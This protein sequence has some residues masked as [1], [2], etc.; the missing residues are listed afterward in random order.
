MTTL[1]PNSSEPA[2]PLPTLCIASENLRSLAHNTNIDST[3]FQSVLVSAIQVLDQVFLAEKH[4]AT[5]AISL[6]Q[7]RKLAN[8]VE[9]IKFAQFS[10]R[11]LLNDQGTRILQLQNPSSATEDDSSISWWFHLTEGI[12]TLEEGINWIGSIISGQPADSP[13]RKLSQIIAG[14][15]RSHYD[16]LLEEAENWLMA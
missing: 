1:A 5:A 9:R 11:A 8:M 10:S 7:K 2:P 13:A 4:I 12:E 14:L 3:A 16:E 6:A 15:L